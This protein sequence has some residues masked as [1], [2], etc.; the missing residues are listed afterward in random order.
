MKS[1]V[2]DADFKKKGYRNSMFHIKIEPKGRR[3][4]ACT[5]INDTYKKQA[6][7]FNL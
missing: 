2:S 1:C 5:S 6:I 4:S 7:F 3:T